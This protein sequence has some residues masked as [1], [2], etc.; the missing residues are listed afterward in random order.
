MMNTRNLTATA[1]QLSTLL[2]LT[3]LA[4]LC[5]VLILKL[6]VQFSYMQERRINLIPF[7]DL[8]LADGRMDFMELTL[9]V[10][11]FVPMGV[12]IGILFDKLIFGKKLLWV[13][14]LSALIEGLQYCL[15]IG[16]F[17]ASDLVTNTLGG[18]L[19]I[20][21]VGALEKVLK[22]KAKAQKVVNILAALG[23][24]VL[25]SL[26]I[27]LKMNRLPLKYQ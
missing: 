4:I 11:I 16:A 19:G 17:D 22:N 1:N 26:L 27:L 14:L 23:T 18:G 8:L 24:L 12:Y 25:I 21:I 9:N 6:G 10:L 2:A 20:V 5:W 3:Y 15:K 13:F 7:G